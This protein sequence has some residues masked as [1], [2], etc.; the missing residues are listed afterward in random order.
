MNAE[1]Y[2]IAIKLFK[3]GEL[4]EEGL[5]VNMPSGRKKWFRT[6]ENAQKFIKKVELQL[7]QEGKYVAEYKVMNQEEAMAYMNK[8]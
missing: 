6:R 8:E 5:I 1:Q 4:V 2:Y 7:K 3:E